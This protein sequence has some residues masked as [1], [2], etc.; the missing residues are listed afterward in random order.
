M[1]TFLT[2]I[3]RNT[4]SVQNIKN[5]EVNFCSRIF[6]KFSTQFVMRKNQLKEYF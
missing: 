6:L 3:Q 1:D 2:Q 4:E 5:I